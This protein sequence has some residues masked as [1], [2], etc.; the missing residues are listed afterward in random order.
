MQ[1]DLQSED[2]DAHGGADAALERELA[3]AG[4]EADAGDHLERDE[5]RDGQPA[6]GEPEITRRSA[7]VWTVRRGRVVGVD[8]NIP[9]GEAL[10]AVE[11]TK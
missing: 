10:A 8:F 2:R 4:A 5:A 6:P 11:R 1:D 7:T 9:Y 3:G